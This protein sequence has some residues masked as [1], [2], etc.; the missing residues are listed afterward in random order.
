MRHCVSRDRSL[1]KRARSPAGRRRHNSN[2][3]SAAQPNAIPIAMEPKEGAAASSNPTAD[4]EALLRA[5]GLGVGDP[6]SSSLML[7]RLRAMGLEPTAAPFVRAPMNT[8]QPPPQVLGGPTTAPFVRPP[9]SMPQSPTQMLGPNATPDMRLLP[10]RFQSQEQ[11]PSYD[12]G[13]SFSPGGASIWSSIGVRSQRFNAPATPTPS[14][15]PTP[16]PKPSKL[17]R[18]SA[19]TYHQHPV[20][21]SHLPPAQSPSTPIATTIQHQPSVSEPRLG[22]TATPSARNDNAS[23][24]PDPDIA[25]FFSKLRADAARPWTLEEPEVVRARLLRGPMEGEPGD[26]GARAVVAM[27]ANSTAQVVQLLAKGDEEVRLR[28][29]ARVKRVVDKVLGRSDCHPVFLALLRACEGRFDELGGILDSAAR[30]SKVF[31]VE[32]LTLGHGEEILKE[33]IRVVAPNPNLRETLITNLLCGGLLYDTKGAALLRHCFPMLPYD[34]K[35]TIFQFAISKI[36]EVLSFDGGR[37]CLLE[38][39]ANATNGELRALENTILRYTSTSKEQARQGPHWA[40]N[41][42]SSLQGFIYRDTAGQ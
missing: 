41:L 32:V 29:L 22:V 27:F 35:S 8:P 39:L 7:S 1:Y 28:V 21:M 31:L 11:P 14:E 18:A 38:C 23:V 10:N 42:N 19:D 2:S 24:N 5:M 12:A 4:L 37:M 25:A 3:K 17:L 30:I 16:R 6:S 9:M 36:D 40:T 34:I 15:A 20:F 33:F 26:R 13:A